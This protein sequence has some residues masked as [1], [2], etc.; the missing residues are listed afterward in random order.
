MESLGLK[1]LPQ[2]QQV[3]SL[4]VFLMNTAMQL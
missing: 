4:F 3:N 2:H 1:T